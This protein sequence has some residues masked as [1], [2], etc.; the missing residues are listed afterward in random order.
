MEILIHQEP[1][2]VHQHKVDWR[3]ELSAGYVRTIRFYV[4]SLQRREKGS[5]AKEVLNNQ[6]T[7]CLKALMKDLAADVLRW[8]QCQMEEGS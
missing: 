7:R 3:L 4:T 5:P 6:D 1:I 8:L 2:H